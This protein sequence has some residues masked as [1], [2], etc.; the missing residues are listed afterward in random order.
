MT[1]KGLPRLLFIVQLPPPLHGASMMNSHLLASSLI[2]SR[3]VVDSINLH[4]AESV[5][6]LGK[7]SF[8]KLYRTFA[9]AFR[10][11]GKVIRHKPD[12]VYFNLT[13]KGFAFY[14]DALYVFILKIMRRK[15]VLHLQS[16]GIRENIASNVLRRQL[17]RLVFRN[18]SLICLS[19][20]LTDDF[21]GIYRAKPFFVPNG[22]EIQTE[23][24]GNSDK[25]SSVP[26]ILYLSHYMKTKGVLVLI[27]A[28]AIVRS[29]GLKFKA[30]L[31]GP[32]ADLSVK[33]LEEAVGAKE[34]QDMV[35]VA[36]PKYGTDKIMEFRM[37]DIFVFPTYYEVFGLVILEAMQNSLP[38]VSTLEGAIP[39][40][41]LENET[42]FLVERQDPEML[43]AK[44]EILIRDKD[45]R[46]EMGRKGFERFRNNYTIDKFE[47]NVTATLM[48]ILNQSL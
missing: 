25:N 44:L 43:A 6:Q 46:S 20:R 42:G 37:A 9:Y 40:I 8:E 2:R 47:Q 36:G 12:L 3:F 21:E 33:D 17:Y 24:I 31:I 26:N 29:H 1:D 32:P 15:I 48:T 45:L 13:P 19:P 16:K 34:L 22:I 14:R 10:I 30:R 11:I 18:T 23:S 39:D 5:Q 35:E 38:V 28:L 7:F 27:D 4:F 41:V